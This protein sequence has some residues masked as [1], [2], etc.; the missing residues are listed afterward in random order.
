MP[1]CCGHPSSCPRRKGMEHGQAQRQPTAYSHEPQVAQV[2][3]L[4]LQNLPRS[5]PFFCLNSE[6]HQKSFSHPQVINPAAGWI[7]CTAR[8][9][10]FAA[11]QVVPGQPQD[12]KESP[13]PALHSGLAEDRQLPESKQGQ[14]KGHIPDGQSCPVVKHHQICQVFAYFRN[15]PLE[16]AGKW[17]PKMVHRRYLERLSI[18]Y[19]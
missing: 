19:P 4:P 9:R 17:L 18:D 15:G 3:S 7:A 8:H 6:S 12:L 10:L 1:L 11:P 14:A 13:S 16:M 2:C 5:S